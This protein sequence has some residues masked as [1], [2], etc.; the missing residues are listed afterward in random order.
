MQLVGANPDAQASG[1]NALPGTSNY[2]SGNDPDL[3][4]TGVSQYGGVRYDDVW[5]G[6]DA[7]Y[8]GMQ[9]QLE[10]DFVVEPGA[11]PDTI[12]LAFEGVES[13]SIEDGNL[14]IDTATGDIVQHAPVIYQTAASGRQT[15]EGS[16]TLLADNRVGF[17]VGA[18]D[19]TRPLVIDP[20]LVYSTLLGGNGADGI[21]DVELDASGNA[22]V[23]GITTST[24]FPTTPGVVDEVGD[25]SAVQ[26]DVFV[27]KLSADGT[28]LLWAT[29]LSGS[30]GDEARDLVLDADGNVHIVGHTLSTNFPTTTGAFDTAHFGNTRTDGFVVKL[31]PTGSSLLYSTYIGN[32]ASE[33][34][35]GIDVDAQ[36]KIY[37]GGQ[38][39]FGGG[40]Y[41]TTPGAFDTDVN[42]STDVALSIIDPAGNGASDLVYSTVMGTS[43]PTESIQDLVVDAAGDVFIVGGHPSSSFPNGFTVPATAADPDSGGTREGFAAKLSPD[44]NGTA[45]LQWL[46]HVGGG[47]DSLGE[48]VTEA[49]LDADGNLV[50]VG[51][52]SSSS[53]PTTSGAYDEGGN[54]GVE[55]FIAKISPDGTNFLFSTYLGGGAA[56]P[57]GSRDF[58]RELEID[59][60]GN[61]WIAGFSESTDFPTV[62]PFQGTLSGGR[63]AFLSKLSAD[64][65][66]LLFSTYFGCTGD[67]IADGLAL[68]SSGIP[69]IAGFTTSTTDFPT[70]AGA[71]Q[72]T[73]AGTQDA[74]ITKIDP[75]DSST[76]TCGSVVVNSPPEIAAQF[77]NIDENQTAAGTVTATDPDL[78]DDT[79]TFSITSAVGLDNAK[80]AITASGALSFIAAPDFENPNDVGGTA[81]DNVYLVE[82]E[83]EDGA[84]ETAMATMSVTVDPVNDNSPVFT[85]ATAVNVAENTTAV[86]TATAT[87]ADLPA[88]TVVF[89]IDGGA[90]AGKF[91][92]TAAGVLTFDA[93]PD[94]ENPTDFGTDNVYEV[95]VKA[96]DKNGLTGTA[97]ITINLNDI[98]PVH[99]T[100]AVIAEVQA[101]K[102][103]GDLSNGEANPILNHLNQA[104]KDLNKGKTAHAV[105]KLEQ[106]R[107]EIQ[108]L[109]D[110]DDLSALIGEPLIDTINSVITEILSGPALRAAAMGDVGQSTGVALT[111]ETLQPIVSEAVAYWDRLT[112]QANHL[113]DVSVAVRDLPSDFLGFASPSVVWID[114]DAAGYGWS[115][116]ASADGMDLRSAVFHELGHVLGYDHDYHD[117]EVMRPTLVAG[118]SRL[119]ETETRHVPGLAGLD[120]TLGGFGHELLVGGLGDRISVA[121]EFE[122][123]MSGDAN[124]ESKGGRDDE[125]LIGG[126]TANEDNLASV[127]AAWANWSGGELAA[128][129]IDLGAITD[130]AGRD[131]LNDEQGNDFVIGGVKDKLKP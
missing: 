102:D 30:K 118:Q 112:G 24:D 130:E 21:S 25:G 28:T 119:T 35:N 71:S 84:G 73:F 67:E 95:Q 23:V 111:H 50:V 114:A 14:V 51:R 76:H 65:T 13:I 110:D 48:G 88:Q 122:M 86:Q 90:D 129:L 9:G 108:D 34:F 123:L 93:A 97:A 91:S 16:Y 29:Y 120:R 64:G 54:G 75:N 31:D 121:R 19:A 89:T 36:G 99:D 1:E 101:L 60:A 47:G 81:G 107:D 78:P 15:V 20:V 103:S 85:S 10:Y 83:V 127:D 58:P 43:T 125:L 61:I 40:T 115:L 22:Y 53:F 38:T 42:G 79:Q 109:I 126:L 3:W 105:Q 12:Q 94:F 62:S 80:F 113:A 2:F 26:R 128:A 69:I 87:D 131:D 72:T 49:E 74:F 100:C 116:G 41:P 45:D 5:T 56:G 68:D 11:S 77:F 70:T 117:A 6:I 63:D 27:A 39:G 124:D 92:I 82:V 59:A 55:G 32:G 98:E 106:A 104:K 4:H 96:D 57:S 33:V 8:Y 7:V 66:T 37:I 44:G 46:T 18:Y 52:T 17:D